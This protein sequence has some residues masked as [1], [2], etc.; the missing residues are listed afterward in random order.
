VAL[1]DAH[2]HQLK[3]VALLPHRERAWSG[4]AIPVPAGVS[5]LQVT[6]VLPPQAQSGAVLYVANVFLGK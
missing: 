6:I 1:V 4:V 5:T 2:G 3:R